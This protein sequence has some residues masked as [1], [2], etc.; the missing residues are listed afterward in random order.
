MK[1]IF[2]NAS[3]AKSGGAAAI[4]N[5]FVAAK[6][7]ENNVKYIIAS[8][9]KPMRLGENHIWVEKSTSL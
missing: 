2:V 3:A 5:K 6:E 9:I 8:P 4:L 7:N 1:K